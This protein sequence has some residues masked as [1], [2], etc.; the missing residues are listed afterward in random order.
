MVYQSLKPQNVADRIVAD[1]LTNICRN[2]RYTYYFCT[3]WHQVQQIVGHK[4]GVG[5]GKGVRFGV[6]LGVSL[7]AT[8]GVGVRVGVGV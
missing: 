8:V 2:M 5:V 1:S 6:G 3:D 4:V 7:G